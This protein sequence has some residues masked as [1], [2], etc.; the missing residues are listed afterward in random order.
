MKYMNLKHFK[1]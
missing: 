1:V